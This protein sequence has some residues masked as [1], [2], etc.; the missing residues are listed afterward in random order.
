MSDPIEDPALDKRWNDFD[1]GGSVNPMKPAE[2]RRRG[3]RLRRRNTALATVGA[4]VAV[5]VI[6]TPI[7]VFAGGSSDRDTE[8][9][10]PPT[11]APSPT[12]PG[13]SDADLLT[14][15]DVPPIDGF[16]DWTE[17]PGTPGRTLGCQSESWE[18]LGIEDSVRRDFGSHIPPGPANVDGSTDD[19]A[20]VRSAVLRF[21]DG[22]AAATAYDTVVDLISECPDGIAGE[23][24]NPIDGTDPTGGGA[25]VTRGWSYAAPE[26]CP[27]GCDAAW[28]ERMG[29]A[30]LGDRLVLVSTLRL[31]GPLEPDG[32]DAD[33]N[34][35]FSAA[36]NR[37]Q[38]DAEGGSPPPS[39][40][41]DVASTDDATSV[42][43][44]FPLASGWPGEWE[45]GGRYGPQGP[46]TSIDEFDYVACG[47]ALV[48]PAIAGRLRASWSNVEDFRSRELL[49]LVD[50]DQA[51]AFM[52]DVASFYEACPEEDS[53]DGYTSL[54]Q[55]RATQVGGQSFAVVQNT[56]FDGAPAVGLAVLHF[57]RVG[58]SVL[59]DTASDE[60]GAGLDLESDIEN[61]IAEQEA[62]TAE[63][64]AAMCRF[65]VAGC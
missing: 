28:F 59:I 20:F 25:Q 39:Q 4:A 12:A 56:E 64:V 61:Q 17:H 33:M 27:E 36:I 38:P 65:T 3:D 52:G 45:L 24:S 43:T 53:D 58:R 46:S 15:T 41:S 29:V 9:V 6:A 44:D 51:V 37:A 13:L 35:V 2:V 32:L 49:V 16:T 21:D 7:G 57:V 62:D 60:G 54:R 30:Q 31:G 23:N 47:S 63:V 40:P 34:Q 10:A 22:D 8:P 14:A 26:F 55:I 19:T 5:A 48:P 42:P 50:A 1:P 11:S 18:T